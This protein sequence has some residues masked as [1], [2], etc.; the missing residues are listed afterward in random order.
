[1][2]RSTTNYLF[3]ANSAFVAA[4]SPQ[5]L[6]SSGNLT[7]RVALDKMTAARADSEL[8]NKLG[9]EGYAIVISISAAK[10]SVADETYQF[11]V[12]GTAS[13]GGTAVAVADLTF[14][15]GTASTG[16]W[17]IKVPATTIED[18]GGGVSDVELNVAATLGG[19][20]PSVTIAAAWVAYDRLN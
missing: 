13:G 11:T 8:I 10:V 1:M 12:Q 6:T 3:D 5:T 4:G 7:S 15:A 2:A 20:S 16:T 18:L 17:V 19:T 9:A 14:A